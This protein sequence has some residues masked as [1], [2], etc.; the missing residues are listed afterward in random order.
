MYS[1]GTVLQVEADQLLVDLGGGQ[2]CVAENTSDDTAV[3]SV[4]LVDT[5]SW[6][7]HKVADDPR[8]DVKGVGVVREVLD[9]ELLIEFPGGLVIT[10]DSGVDCDRGYTVE[11][12]QRTGVVRVLAEHPLRGTGN[13]GDDRQDAGRYEVDLSRLEETFDDLGGMEHQLARARRLIDLSLNKREELAAIGGRPI[14]GVLFTGPPGTGKTM[15]ARVIAKE[16]GASFFQIKGP[17][18]FSKWV[19]ESE[20]MI[21]RVFASATAKAPAIIFFDEIDAIAARRGE[22]HEAGR[23]VVAQLLTEMDGFSPSKHVVVIAATNRKDFL[24]PA[25]LRPGRFDWQVPFDAL[26]EGGRLAVLRASGQRIRQA[27]GLPLARVAAETV[28]WSAARL[29][30]VWSEAALLALADDRRRVTREDLLGGFAA[31][32]SRPEAGDPAAGTPHRGGGG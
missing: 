7:A 4:V 26:D 12:G 27:S 14:R 11:A 28:G 24:D 9:N 17:Q 10:P 25:L 23:Q 16:A 3:G 18:I 1:I 15:L 29:A 13:G 22:G 31:V 19:G 6:E 2:V 21:R 30:A 5:G 20:E 8:P 32:K